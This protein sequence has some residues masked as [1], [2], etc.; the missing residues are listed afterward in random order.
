MPIEVHQEY[1]KRRYV[2]GWCSLACFIN[3]LII[4]GAAILPLYIAW[5]S[6]SFWIKEVMRWEQPVVTY[7][8]QAA[9]FLTGMKGVGVTA[10]PFQLAWTTSPSGNDLLGDSVRAPVLKSGTSDFNVDGKP[11][12]LRISMSMPLAGDEVITGVTA[13]AWLNVQLTT[14]A[15]MRM[16]GLA[17]VSYSNPTPGASFV[18]DGDL[19]IQQRAPVP[20]VVDGIFTPFMASPLPEPATAVRLQQL[21]PE[22][23]LAIYRSRN[24]TTLFDVPYPMWT[25]DLAHNPATPPCAAVDCQPLQ[26]R[27]FAVSMKVRIAP[28]G[29]VVRPTV[30]E[31]LKHG[32]IQYVA[33]LVLT[34]L[35]AWLLRKII[36]GYHI[37]ET[38]VFVD[39]PR[40]KIRVE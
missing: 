7:K 33:F 26:P 35:L 25:P 28:T 36:F 14:I 2:S 16:D 20:N 9:F 13:I 38:S 40:A 5:A 8:S 31:E 18:A 22:A 1:L 23:V 24:Y 15:R 17:A 10:R 39:A 12:E 29:V 6:Q 4:L 30:S 32:Y 19:T 34:A 37:L 27:N 21:L 11:D 3:F